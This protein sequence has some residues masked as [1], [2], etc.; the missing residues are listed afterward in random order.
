M[1]C[2]QPLMH[3]C[4][5]VSVNER[6]Q[7]YLKIAALLLEDGDSVQAE[8]YVNRA[9]GIIADTKEPLLIMQHKVRSHHI[10]CTVRVWTTHRVSPLSYV[11]TGQPRAQMR[12][13]LIMLPW[14]RFTLAGPPGSH[15]RQQASGKS[16]W[17]CD[18]AFT[19]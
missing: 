7:V 4:R 17:V 2:P 14:C 18:G 15:P 19:T 9:S 11:R 12:G 8:T 16:V 6:L 5:A 13:S 3:R 10:M 1:P